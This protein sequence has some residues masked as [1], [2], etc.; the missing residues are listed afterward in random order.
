MQLIEV[1]TKKDKKDFLEFPLSIYKPKGFTEEWQRNWIRPLN[2]DIEG[3]FDPKGNKFFRH[4]DA[5]RWLLKDDAGKIIGRIAA[6][7]NEKTS[8]KEEQP[9][10]GLGFFDC[11]DDMKAAT[12]LFEKGKE[13]LKAKGMEAMD[14]PVNFGERD[15]WWGLLVEGFHEPVYCMNY[16]PPYYKKFFDDYGFKT[17][18][19]QIVFSLKVFDP[20]Q[21]KF[22][23]RHARFAADPEYKAEH[24]DK[25]RIEKY[26][27]DFC[28]IYN[29]AWAKHG[30]GKSM[31]KEQALLIFKK[32]KPVMDEKLVWFVYYKNEPIACWLNL[33]ELNQIFKHLNGKFDLFH[34]LKFLWLKRKGTGG[35]FYGIVFG[36]IPEFQGKGIDAY[37]IVE[38]ANVIRATK[39]YYDM[40]LQWI[41]DFN[42]KMINVSESLGTKRSRKLITYRYLFDRSKE[43][44]RTPVINV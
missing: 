28:T 17:L 3:V 5:I 34:K 33:P 4:G 38:G 35:K 8:K 14:G 24:I 42:P 44:K 30:G 6:F 39:R 23:E 1:K 22:E 20:L 7:Y 26:A 32:M 41:G 21:D 10:G 36:V 15:R 43:F 25:S 18:F 12:M 11:I 27:G 13:W 29:K 9:T 31:P 37:M 19:E 2:H 16:N 40:E